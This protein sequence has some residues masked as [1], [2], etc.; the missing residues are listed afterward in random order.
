M[1][2]TFFSLHDSIGLTDSV[3][4][5]LSCVDVEAGQSCAT[6]IGID[7]V[8]TIEDTLEWYGII[9]FS[10]PDRSSKWWTYVGDTTE[11]QMELK[12]T[13]EHTLYWSMMYRGPGSA[14]SCFDD[15][16]FLEDS[17]APGSTWS[18]QLV[19]LGGYQYY[20]KIDGKP[21]S[22]Y[23]LQKSCDS[24]DT[25]GLHCA[26]AISTICQDS[27]IAGNILGACLSQIQPTLKVMVT[28]THGIPR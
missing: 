27:L 16:L 21:G 12:N 26:G 14:T 6:A 17:I 9:D 4:F 3:Q 2:P 8:S 19:L 18:R 24:L 13:G 25:K 10:H 5:S 7:C 23:L 11:M 28:G 20:F 15:V 1:R 22:T